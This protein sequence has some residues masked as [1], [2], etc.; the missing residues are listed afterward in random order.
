MAWNDLPLSDKARM[1][2]LAVESGITD[3]RTIEEVYNKFAEGGPVDRR[4][5][6]GV[7]VSEEEYKDL[8]RQAIVDAAVEKALTRKT[9]VAPTFNDGDQ[10]G[11]SCL[12]TVTDNFGKQYLVSGNQSLMANPEQYGYA[13]AGPLSDNLN[14]NIGRIYQQIDEAGIPYHAMLVT[15][16]D[17]DQNLVT[18][19]SG[20]AGRQV[21]PENRF[22]ALKE[23]LAKDFSSAAVFLNDSGVLPP[24]TNE[25][26]K[27]YVIRGRKAKEEEYKK[28]KKIW[29]SP[30][31]ETYRFIGTPQDNVNW[32]NQFMELP[33]V[34]QIQTVNN[35]YLNQIL[36]EQATL[37]NGGT[38]HIKPSHKGKFTALKKRTGHSASWF[39]AHGTPAQKKMATFALNARKWHHADGG[40]LNE[41]DYEFLESPNIFERGGRKRRPE[42]ASNIDTDPN[43]M[44]PPRAAE[45]TE[46]ISRQRYA[47]STYNDNAYNRGSKAAGAFQITPSVYQEY[48]A[49]TGNTGDLYD[50]MFNKQVRD[51]YMNDRLRDFEMYRL[52]NPTDSV[53]VGRTYA[54]YNAGP[55]K[56]RAALKKAQSE[57][58]DIDSTFNWLT[59][60][61]TETQDY[62]NFIV[63][64]QDIPDSS[65]TQKAYKLV[66]AL[67][68][69]KHKCGGKLYTK[70]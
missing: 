37:K 3:L 41:A 19:S 30:Q 42:A 67:K 39:K 40:F 7:P 26:Y 1:M 70:I 36:N 47:E 55:G 61:P 14:E 46:T 17:G 65:K 38:I 15:G 18:Y 20:A 56:V 10:V 12:Y 29:E 34:E 45:S 44:G 25:S 9:G 66:K 52:G 11:P 33:L 54:A 53:R 68:G 62:V 57:G 69:E 23:A 59:Y 58:V 28:N 2:Q 8:Q 16:D 13:V 6:N 43:F 31:Y 50:P 27:D 32:S 51:W 21:L 35:P 48:T 22:N 5:Y 63:R 24:G 64:E 60:L 49:K 4:I